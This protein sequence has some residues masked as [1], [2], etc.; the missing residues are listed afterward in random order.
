MKT[1]RNV[2]LILAF[3]LAQHTKISAQNIVGDTIF[4]T[5]NEDLQVKFPSKQ[6]DTKWTAAEGQTPD[7]E[8]TKGPSSIYLIALNENAKCANLGVIEGGSAVR[9][10]RFTVCYNKDKKLEEVDY[11]TI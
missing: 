1:R 8:I 10:H 6:I 9:A 11:G 5:A 4:V 7:F 2:F 3:I